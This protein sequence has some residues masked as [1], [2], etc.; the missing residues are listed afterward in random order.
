MSNDLLKLLEEM[1]DE[2]HER[3]ESIQKALFSYP[4]G[5][6]KSLKYIL[7]H[8][9]IRGA[10]IEP[11]GGSAAVLLARKESPLEVYNDRYGGVVDFYRCIRDRALLDELCERLTLTLHSREEFVWCKQTWNQPE[12]IVERAARWYYMTMYSFGKQGRNFG[13]AI[14]HSCRIAGQLVSRLPEFP[15]VHDRLRNVQI[16]N[17]DW[18]YCMKDYDY[19]EAVFYCDPPYIDASRGIY[20]SELTHDEHKKFLDIVMSLS[21]FVAVSSYPNKLYDSY[22][23]D[24]YYSW[25]HFESTTSMAWTESNHKQDQQHVG[26][27]K[28]IEALYIKEAS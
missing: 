20:K 6:A 3:E 12:S 22:D 2:P 17:Q 7:P 18:Y 9:P 15:K 10:Y 24:D 14:K 27:S 8:L 13:R 21:G 23:W 4:G 28:V 1:D 5:K 26:R 25:E 19:P 16:E 11:F